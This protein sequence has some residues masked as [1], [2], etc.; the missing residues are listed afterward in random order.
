MGEIDKYCVYLRKSRQDIEAEKVGDEET[1]A[2]HRRILTEFAAKQGLYIEKIYS[3]V[4]SGETIS[5]RPEMQKMIEDCYSGAYRGIIVVEVTRL[6]RGNQGDAQVIIDCLKYANNN[7]GLLVI[8]PTKTYD[9]AHNSDDETFMEFELFMSR[10]EYAMIKKRMNRGKLQCVVEG[11]YM[12]SYRPYGWEVVRIGKKRTLTPKED[13]YEIGKMMYRWK[14]EGMTTGDIARK[15][16]LMG[17][18]TYTG[19]KEWSM[20]SVK[21]FLRNPVNMGKVRWNDR[22]QVKTM[23]NGELVT[24]RPRSTHS[25]Q[26]MLYDGIH[27]GKAMVTE[28]EWMAATKDFTA[29]K[30]KS[31]LKLSN[32]LAGILR[33]KNCGKAM[34]YNG[35]QTKKNVDPRFR[36]PS[37][38]ICKVKSVKQKDVMAAIV[39]ALKLYMED[40]QL[41]VDNLPDVDEDSVT[42]QIEALEAQKKK[43]KKKLEKIFDDYEEGIYTANEFVQR[44]A[45]L[46]ERIESIDQQIHELE[47]AIPEKVDYQEMVLRLS[48]ALDALLDDEVEAEVKNHFL[49]ELFTKIEFSRENN[50]E[51]ILDFHLK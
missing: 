16:T 10:R 28:E 22:M 45:V 31:G 21:D 23:K 15:L 50:D 5:A 36:H 20:A 48:D 19:Q 42:T 14:I 46:T 12:S 30:T 27:K 39:H 49:K 7:Q 34:V 24:S 33:C 43:T 47:N 40:F 6:S 18:P 37:S 8:T 4:V 26:Y 51:F 11:E 1:L 41:K 25:D 9:V 32:P 35:Y 13:E 17:V 29:D 2:K 38:Q 44:K 3:E